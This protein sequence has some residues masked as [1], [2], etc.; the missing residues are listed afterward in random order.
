M[1]VGWQDWLML[2]NWLDP[3]ARHPTIAFCIRPGFLA[4]YRRGG[5]HSLHWG[6][7]FQA[8][9]APNTAMV[10]RRT[11]VVSDD[12]PRTESHHL[13]WVSESRGAGSFR[14]RIL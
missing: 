10:W 2:V 7:T 8:L 6:P 4:A 3:P 13:S 12:P 14:Y 5:W 9:V 11:R 1:E